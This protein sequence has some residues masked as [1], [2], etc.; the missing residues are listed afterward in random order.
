MYGANVSYVNVSF[1]TNDLYVCV[2]F[3]VTSKIES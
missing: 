3:H 2:N 1:A